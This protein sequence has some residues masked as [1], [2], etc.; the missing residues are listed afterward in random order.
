MVEW[1][2]CG[3]RQRTF[4]EHP[5]HVG[6]LSVSVAHN[7]HTRPF[8]GLGQVYDSSRA[9]SFE[10]WRRA[11]PL[12]GYAKEQVVHVPLMKLPWF[13]TY[14]SHTTTHPTKESKLG[15]CGKCSSQ[16]HARPLLR[17]SAAR[18]VADAARVRHAG[19]PSS[20]CATVRTGK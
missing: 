12:P 19:S 11:A 7:E 18:L 16:M 9:L 5:E 2:G 4:G 14:A 3:E 1:V 13:P 6:K 15:C 17:M 20:L 8:A 10:A